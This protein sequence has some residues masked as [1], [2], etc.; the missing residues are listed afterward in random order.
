[1]KKEKF[2]KKYKK[3]IL[4]YTDANNEEYEN[5]SEMFAVTGN[6]YEYICHASAYKKR[7]RTVENEKN[8]I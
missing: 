7:L 4:E 5:V 1:M 2:L 8:T 6:G 3:L